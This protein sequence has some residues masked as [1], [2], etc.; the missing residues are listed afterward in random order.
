[1]ETKTS[2]E[3]LQAIEQIVAEHE[4]LLNYSCA[5]SLPDQI[6]YLIQHYKD[7]TVKAVSQIKAM[8]DEI[9]VYLRAISFALEAE[10]NGGTHAERNARLRGA[11]QVIQE[12]AKR[13]QDESF[14]YILDREWTWRDLFHSN[15]EA[16]DLMNR[17]YQLEKERDEL[18]TRLNIQE[19]SKC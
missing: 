9:L 7:D 2:E 13:L 18:K 15:L 19:S 17:I 10:F 11:L 14:T 6:K 3:I 8:R 1:M 4:K 16:R 12:T 5:M